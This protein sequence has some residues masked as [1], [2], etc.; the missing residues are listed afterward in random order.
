MGSDFATDLEPKRN[1]DVEREWRNLPTV[2]KRATSYGCL[3]AAGLILLSCATHRPLSHGSA[4]VDVV[5]LRSELRVSPLGIDVPQPRLSWRLRSDVRETLQTAYQLRVAAS[6]AALLAS[7]DLSWDT[8]RIVSGESTQILYAGPTLHSRQR[9]Y[10]QVRVW[11]QNGAISGWSAPAMWEMGLLSP[12]D[13][14]ARW[15]ESQ[16]I[17]DRVPMFRRDFLL[18]GN[19]RQARAYVTSRGL[20]QLYLNGRRV[21][22]AELTP[23]WTSYEKRLQYQTYDVTDLMVKGNN[24]T[25]AFLGEGWYRGAFGFQGAPH[26]YGEH[27]ALLV[28]LEINYEDGTTDRIVSDQQ[29]RTSTGPILQSSIIAGESYDARLEQV[30]WLRSGFDDSQWRAARAIDAPLDILIAQSGP[31]VRKIQE[32]FPRAITAAPD[33]GFIVD[34]GQNMV[35]WVR[36]SVR[37]PAGTVVTLRHGEVLD[38]KGNLY[39]DNLR[40]AKQTVRYTLKGSDVEVYE[41]HFTFQGFRYVAV[42]GYPGKPTPKDIVGIV[43]HSDIEHGG[44][45]ET[46]NPLLNQLQHNIVWGENGNFVDIPTDCPQRD[47]RLGWTGDAE[48]FAPT[49]AFN[50]DVEGFFSKWLKD[51]AADQLANGSVPWVVPNVLDVM[52]DAMRA[53]FGEATAGAAGWGDAATVIPWTLYLAYGDVQVLQDQYQSMNRWVQFERERAGKDLVWHGGFQFADWLD[54]GSAARNNFGATDPDLVATAYFAHSAD[55]LSR[56]ARVLNRPADAVQDAELFADVRAAFQ[57]KF[58]ASDGSVG[59]GTQT[60]Y[61]LALQFGLVPDNLSAAAAQHLADDVR[62]QGHLTTGFLGTPGILF[63][64]SE[65]GYLD[66]AYHLLL[67][68]EYPSWLYPVKHGATTIWERWDGVKE[69]GTFQSPG[70]NSFNHYAYGAVG[71]WMYRV[72]AGINSDSAAP[73]YKHILIE[74]HPGGGLTSA[75]ASHDTP[76]GKVTSSWQEADGQFRL[77]V[78]IPPNTTARLTLPFAAIDHILED[79]KPISIADGIFAVRQSGSQS[80]VDIGSGRYEFSYAISTH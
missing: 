56:A 15:V 53:V 19:V 55:L 10:W 6:Q 22:D 25:G 11:N 76:Y 58:V 44:D 57:R 1:T 30:G 29:W 39:T 80:V 77:A 47:E 7:S 28:Q 37:G 74:P 46:S 61:V 45:F 52:P 35:G 64:L 65:N 23:G 59:T 3:M 63:A 66:V 79:G 9:I 13:W 21:G 68:D 49:A 70:M 41:P 26:H 42:A 78:S 18:R 24:A 51:L 67:R 5:D 32:I 72:V 34:M 12:S 27:T 38:D 71:D 50:A 62:R 20:Y 48:V 36:L 43:V 75:S 8:G 2:L 14:S 69:D 31:P 54:F 60:G 16:D 33:G 17:T 73:G 4:A 40:T